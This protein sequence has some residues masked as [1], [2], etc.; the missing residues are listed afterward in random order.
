MVTADTFNSVKSKENLVSVIVRNIKDSLVS[1]NLKPGEMLPPIA[2]MAANMNVGVSSVREALKVLEALCVVKIVHGKGIYVCTDLSEDSINP[3]TFQLMIIPKND[4]DLVE[5]R[6]MFETAYTLMALNNATQEDIDKIHDILIAFIER[7]KTQSFN[8]E[9]ELAFHKAILHA[10]HNKYVIKIGETMLDLFMSS[11]Q[12]T[13]VREEEFSVEENHTHIYQAICSKDEAQM[14]LA[15]KESF[16]GW[17][18][19]YFSD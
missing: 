4:N 3:L 7:D 9:H 2:V 18:T 10:T 12:K 17:K 13:P 19:K 16:D 15:L 14:R 1:G 6:G 5:F 8:S 11:I